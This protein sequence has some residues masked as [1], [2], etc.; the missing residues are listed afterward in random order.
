MEIPSETHLSAGETY[1][2]K[3]QLI[4][5]VREFGQAIFQ[6][7]LYEES[8]S[9]E[10]LAKTSIELDP[11]NQIALRHLEEAQNLLEN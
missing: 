3:R 11:Y 6:L 9:Y 4:E 7:E 5:A 1:F 10:D 8:N 2:E